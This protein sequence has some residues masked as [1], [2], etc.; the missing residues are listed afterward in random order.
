MCIFVRIVCN[1]HIYIRFV[2]SISTYYI[3]I[4]LYVK[5]IYIY[6]CAYIYVYVYMYICLYVY[7]CIYKYIYIDLNVYIYI[8]YATIVCRHLSWMISFSSSPHQVPCGSYHRF[9]HGWCCRFVFSHS[10]VRRAQVTGGGGRRQEWSLGFKIDIYPSIPS[11][12]WNTW[13]LVYRKKQSFFEVINNSRGDYYFNGLW[14]S[15]LNFTRVHIYNYVV[16]L[17]FF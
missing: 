8:L 1:I 16:L 15:I 6:V 2:H 5:Y 13:Q 4:C 9:G 17:T 10:T 14:M 7:M 12:P 3:R 11:W